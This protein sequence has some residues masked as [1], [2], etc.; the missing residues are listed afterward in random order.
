MCFDLH[1][2]SAS[3]DPTAYL[4]CLPVHQDGSCN[5][6]QHYAALARD[7]QGAQQVNLTP[8]DRRLPNLATSHRAPA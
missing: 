4:S 7:V 8:D 2:A 5:G 3:D 6:L 1:A